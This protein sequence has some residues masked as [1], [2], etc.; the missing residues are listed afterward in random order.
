MST[1]AYRAP[2]GSV[3][4]HM[5][6]VLRSAAGYFH[7]PASGAAALPK[8]PAFSPLEFPTLAPAQMQEERYGL[9]RRERRQAGNR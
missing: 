6:R 8:D 2:F 3:L 4:A 7:W 1:L 9:G 5:S